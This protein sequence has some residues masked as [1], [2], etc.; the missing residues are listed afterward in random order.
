MADGGEGAAKCPFHEDRKAS[1]SVNRESGLWFC[2]ACNVGGTAHEFAERLRVEARASNRKSAEHVFNYRDERGELLY[3]VVRFAGK[4][5][6]QRRPDGKGGWLWNLEGVRRVP[7]R[8]PEL[9]ASK[10][11]V[12]IVEGEKDVETIRAQGLTA[13]CNSGGSG[14]WREFRRASARS[15]LHFDRGQRRAGPRAHARRGADAQSVHYAS[16]QSR[17]SRPSRKG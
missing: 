8:L 17:A 11:N 13:T 1:L 10:G 15:R 4:K 14:K 7:Y 2:H 6:S 5:F 16:H 3:Q 9:L 12:F